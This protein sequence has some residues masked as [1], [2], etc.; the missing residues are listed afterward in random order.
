MTGLDLAVAEELSSAVE[1]CLKFL[2][3][4]FDEAWGPIMK[5]NKLI[6]VSKQPARADKSAVC[7]INRHLRVSGLFS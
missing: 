7:A 2:T 6:G 5:F 1:P 3:W 4:I